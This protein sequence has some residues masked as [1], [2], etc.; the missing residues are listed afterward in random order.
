MPADWLPIASRSFE[1]NIFGDMIGKNR[2]TAML[3]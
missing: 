1:K 3:I 2:L